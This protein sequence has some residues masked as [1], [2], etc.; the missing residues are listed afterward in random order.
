MPSY[1]EIILVKFY[2][3]QDNFLIMLQLL[4]RVFSE[5]GLRAGTYTGTQTSRNDPIRRSQQITSKALESIKSNIRMIGLL[6]L[7]KETLF[8]S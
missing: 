4:R 6:L 2:C 8:V 1:S 5:I 3:Y 7:L